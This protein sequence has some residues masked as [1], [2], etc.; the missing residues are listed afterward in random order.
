MDELV[1][2]HRGPDAVDAAMHSGHE[3][4]R[5]PEGHRSARAALCEVLADCCA[6]Q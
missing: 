4:H 5:R 1:E 2:M 6:C 3:D